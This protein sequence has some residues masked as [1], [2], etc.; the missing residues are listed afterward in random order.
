MRKILCIFAHP[1]LQRSRAN[2][3]IIDS[4]QGIPGLT[5]RSLYDLFPDFYIEPRREQELVSAHDALVFQ[6]PFFWYSMPPLMKLWIDTVLEYGWAYGPEGKALEGK[7][8]LLSITAGGPLDSYRPEGYNSYPVESFFPPYQ[9]TARLCG[10]RW[11]A[12]LVLHHSTRVG[13]AELLAHAEHVRDR[14]RLLA[15]ERA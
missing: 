2:R 15:T 10:M 12:P 1:N 4:M 8:F 14:V 7:D 9:Q 3:R 11:Q 13:D 6:H 5:I